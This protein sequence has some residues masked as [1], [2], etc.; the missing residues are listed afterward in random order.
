MGTAQLLPAKSA[1]RG[2]RSV[3]SRKQRPLG[4]DAGDRPAA[5]AAEKT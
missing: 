5:L 2:Q 1:P 3:G 4:S